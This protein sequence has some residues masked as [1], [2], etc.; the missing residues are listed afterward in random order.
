MDTQTQTSAHPAAD[1]THPAHSS[2]NWGIFLAL[3]TVGLQTAGQVV[4]PNHPSISAALAGGS[5][6]LGSV[7]QALIAAQPTN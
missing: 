4:A 5:T 3:L 6:V 2:F 7:D 1:P